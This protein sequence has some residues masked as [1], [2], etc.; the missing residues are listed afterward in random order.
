M[1]GRLSLSVAELTIRDKRGRKTQVYRML[2]HNDLIGSL[3]VIAEST[4]EPHTRNN[5]NLLIKMIA[6]LNP[7]V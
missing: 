2:N 3:T 1:A 5:I 7:N 6:D 4:R